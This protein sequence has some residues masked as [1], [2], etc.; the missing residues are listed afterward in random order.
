MKLTDFGLRLDTAPL[1]KKVTFQTTLLQWGLEF[2]I[3]E[4]QTTLDEYGQED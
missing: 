4:T 1:E 2:E 3:P